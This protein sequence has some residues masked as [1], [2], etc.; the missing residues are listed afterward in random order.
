METSLY[1]NEVYGFAGGNVSS[2][3]GKNHVEEMLSKTKS[4][5]RNA[6]IKKIKDLI[7][8]GEIVDD[9]FKTEVENI[10]KNYN[11]IKGTGGIS[12][13]I[14]GEGK[15][16]EIGKGVNIF[17]VVKCPT[18]IG[19]PP[20]TVHTYG[21]LN[22]PDEHPFYLSFDLLTALYERMKYHN[23]LVFRTTKPI[24]CTIAEAN[25]F[26]GK[27]FINKDRIIGWNIS[28]LYNSLFNLVGDNDRAYYITNY[29]KNNFLDNKSSDAILY[30]SRKLKDTNESLITKHRKIS[31]KANFFTKR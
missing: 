6:L 20:A 28:A 23:L 3:N 29:I 12:Y 16:I 31:T 18:Y 26:Q 14:L 11:S 10:I 30:P 9:S 19:L 8:Q 17:R 5:K 25:L 4:S 1:T 24:K 22:T 13:T 2:T 27:Q 7:K 21:R 15:V